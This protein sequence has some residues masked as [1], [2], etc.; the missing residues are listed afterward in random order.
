M[1]T[2]IYNKGSKVVFEDST[3]RTYEASKLRFNIVSSKIIFYYEANDR[4]AENIARVD[5]QNESG[6]TYA[7]DKLAVEY[8]SNFKTDVVSK[9]DE[10][11]ILG[12]ESP[13]AT[14]NTD[15]YTVPSGKMINKGV[16]LVANRGLV[17]ANFRVALRK[18]GVVLA[19][20]H[21]IYYDVAVVTKDTFHFYDMK[22]DEADVVTV[23]SSNANLSFTLMGDIISK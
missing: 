15:I 9:N 23:Y 7:T 17:N 3:F 16:L 13:L 20:K 2:K 10:H 21:Y 11:G 14:T 8:L 4:I 22:L 12:Q 1:A 18:A 6:G 19:A 5:L